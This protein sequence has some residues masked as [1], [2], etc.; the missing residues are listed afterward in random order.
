MDYMELDVRRPRK[1]PS[2]PSFRNN[3][4]IIEKPTKC[5]AAKKA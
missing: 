4:N 3:N 1:G 2:F 5:I